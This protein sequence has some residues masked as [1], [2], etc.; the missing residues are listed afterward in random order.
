[1]SKIT[2]DHIESFSIEL[3]QS[4][5]WQYIHG[6]AIVPGAELFSFYNDKNHITVNICC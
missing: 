2:E 1:M 4:L 3:L 6:L 5:G